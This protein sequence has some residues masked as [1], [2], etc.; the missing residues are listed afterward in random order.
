ME[1]VAIFGLVC[2]VIQVVD[3][4]NKVLSTCKELYEKGSL[5]EHEDLDFMSARL[6]NL[7]SDLLAGRQ[8]SSALPNQPGR[9]DVIE[10]AGKCS[11]TAL[12]LHE[13]LEKLKPSV[14]GKKYEA[15]RI[16]WK[17]IWRK[18]NLEKLEKD[19][20]SFQRI[21]NTKILSNIQ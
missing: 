1:P 10:L 13:E 14:S 5:A 21:L 18:K 3:F 4:S 2:G 16:S 15:F 8:R 9:Q 12:K 19:L 20:H 6:I 7:R 11:Q 17:T